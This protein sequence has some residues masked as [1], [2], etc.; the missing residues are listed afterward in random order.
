MPW[1]PEAPIVGPWPAER[2]VEPEWLDALSA[3]D[4]RAIR[5]RRD[6]RRVNAWMGETRIMA[7]LLAS[8]AKEPP[9]RIADL[10][11]GDGAFMLRVARRLVPRWPGVTVL[12]VDR[13][14]IVHPE[15]CVAFE[16]LGWRAEPAAE[17]VFD[18]LARPISAV[19]IVTANLFLHHF[20]APDLVR[21]FAGAAK[22]APLFV[23]CEP[24]RSAFA[25]AASN[26][27]WAIGC[28][29][30]SRHDAAVSVRA[31]FAR[32][33]L[34]ALWPKAAGWRL[35]ERPAGLFTHCFAAR[36]DGP[37]G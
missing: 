31:G 4:P 19:D 10:G 11:G 9:R 33:E 35:V 15:T 30:V 16:A 17:D 8:Q 12:L 34:S 29:A 36:C 18:F 2:R 21:L 5:S 7:R 37:P 25:L 6:L 28:N 14:N 20:H 23:A 27:L 1:A 13:Q 22:L 32:S 3:T 24:R 26:M